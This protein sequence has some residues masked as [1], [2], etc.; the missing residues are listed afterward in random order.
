[1]FKSRKGVKDEATK[2][3]YRNNQ[4]AFE[5]PDPVQPGVS[6]VSTYRLVNKVDNTDG[7]KKSTKSSKALRQQ[8][9]EEILAKPGTPVVYL[10]SRFGSAKVL[11]DGHHF[12]YH[13]TAK[14]ISYYRCEQFKRFNCP[15]TIL[16]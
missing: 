14:S 3:D 5:L 2:A 15:A 16:E 1:M 9:V 10:A 4:S 12:V 11:L 8:A 7:K 6:S 13:F